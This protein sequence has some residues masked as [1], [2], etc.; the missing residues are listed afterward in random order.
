MFRR[1]V[2]LFAI[3]L[4]LGPAAAF[5]QN[6]NKEKAAVASAEKWLG[7]VDQGDY[8]ESWKE[9]AAYLRKGMTEQKWV[10]ILEDFRAPLGKMIART[11]GDAVSRTSLQ[12]APNGEYVLMHF[13]TSFAKNKAAIETVISILDKDG[14]WRV[15]AYFCP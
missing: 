1:I 10:H 11:Q 8:A 13:Y 7:L 2:C 5:A 6:A 9:A 12:G 15:A 14:K 3:V 4:I